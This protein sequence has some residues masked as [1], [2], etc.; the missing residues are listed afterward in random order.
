MGP[1]NESIIAPAKISRRYA[2]SLLSGIDPGW[3]A[4]LPRGP[5]G[6]V[7]NTNHP[8]FVYGHL[9]IYPARMLAMLGRADDSL[10]LPAHAASLFQA[11]QPCRDDP[12]CTIYPPLPV[13]SNLLLHATDAVLDA[14]A[15]TPE[16][17]LAKP[18]PNEQSR[19]RLPTIGAAITFYLTG[20]T[21]SHLGQVSAWRR[22][23]GLPSVM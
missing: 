2:E 18:H 6:E 20:H 1:W 14:L 12:Q 22:C 19:G 23:M 13:L 8:V 16:S 5:R 10:T 21:M 17:I 3:A 15:D 7:I 11:G 9:A 4:T